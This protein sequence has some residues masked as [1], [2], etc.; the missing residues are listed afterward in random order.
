MDIIDA[1]HHYWNPVLNNH[2]WL[3]EEPMIPF[4]Y[5]DYSTIRRPFLP[6]D[7]DQV[8]A[9]WNV[10]ATVTMEGE[11]TPDDPLGEARWMNSL[12]Q[13]S[14]KPAAHVAQAWLD[15]N[16]IDEVLD[17]LESLAFVKSIRHKPRSNSSPGG[18]S[19]GMTDTSFIEGFK[20]LIK[21]NL[22]F[23]L[24]TPWWHLDEAAALATMSPDTPIILNH[25]G[26]PSDRSDEGIE[27]WLAA[28]KR[29]AEL[30]QVFVKISGL[31]L[32]YKPWSIDDNCEIILQTIDCFGADRCMFASNFPVDGL[33]GTFDTI[34]NGF[35][36][37]TRSF[38]VAER[39]A[40]FAGNAAKVYSLTLE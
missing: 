7:Y 10:V 2:P 35:D 15:R 8:S 40:L 27:G 29:F 6:E 30:P 18:S 22:M 1:H 37:V 14:G 36:A 28:M 32:A 25:T 11:W 20:K 19:G 13:S 21:H 12:N 33:C 24:Q 16:D 23:D 17:E 4:R 39:E 9:E 26:L 34:Y 5:G 3:I 38:S 31:G